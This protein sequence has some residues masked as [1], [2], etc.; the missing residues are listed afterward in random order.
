MN[1]GGLRDLGQWRSVAGAWLAQEREGAPAPLPLRGQCPLCREDVAFEGDPS[2]GNIREGLHCRNC[3]ATARQRSVA[4]VLLQSLPAPGQA[5]VYATEQASGFYRLL[6]RQVGRLHGGEYGLGL[7]RRLRLQA[8]MWRHGLYQW[9]RLRDVTALDFDDACLDAVV[10]LDVLEHVPDTARALRE[11]ARVLRPGGVLVFSVPFYQD[12][13]HST[14]VAWFQA[15]GQLA[16]A[17]EPE[18]HGDPVSG[19]VLCFHHFGWDLVARL[20]EAGF[21]DAEVLRVHDPRAGLPQGQWVFR[22]TR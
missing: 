7:A 19:G 8:W 14:R 18:Y 4:A 2:A 16:F 6:R 22:A 17:G 21:R 12:A 10:S 5:R 20:R 3:G 13:A 1:R 15:D 11:M 9:L